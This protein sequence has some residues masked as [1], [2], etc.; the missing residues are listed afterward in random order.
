MKEKY[1]K[2]FCFILGVVSVV[3]FIAIFGLYKT[4]KDSGKEDME[5]SPEQ[6]Y[7]AQVINKMEMENIKYK[8]RLEVGKN[9][10]QAVFK[11]IGEN[12]K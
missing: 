10:E 7:V 4:L 6:Y 9:D 5:I 11:I 2:V 8:I 12:K 3:L 1:I